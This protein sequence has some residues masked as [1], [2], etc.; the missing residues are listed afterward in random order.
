MTRGLL[1][2]ELIVRVLER[3]RM[4]AYPENSPRGLEAL[5]RA[6]CRNVPFDNIR[7]LIALRAN[8]SGPLP[9]D[10][11]QEFLEAFLAHGVGGTCWA[12]NGALCTLLQALGFDAT[13]AV[14]T[15]MVAPGLPP[16]HGSV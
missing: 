10:D 12:G 13:R 11:P 14:A 7:K 5:Y 8:H 15:M 6:W 1:P 16:N 4:P 9:G 3:L 2:P